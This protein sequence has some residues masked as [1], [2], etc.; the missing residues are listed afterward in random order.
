M[1]SNSFLYLSLYL[2]MFFINFLHKSLLHY[3]LYPFFHFFCILYSV[4]HSYVPVISY[5]LVTFRYSLYLHL[6]PSLI[7]SI[8]LFC[9]SLEFL[10]QVSMETLYPFHGHV[11]RMH[12]PSRTIDFRDS[13][14]AYSNRVV[15]FINTKQAASP[16]KVSH[17]TLQPEMV[18]KMYRMQA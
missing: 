7:A 10:E 2:L 9:H 13:A 5:S 1:E 3:P 11:R 6:F 4:S 14:L 15:Y 8:A 18:L 17:R 16:V 12:Q